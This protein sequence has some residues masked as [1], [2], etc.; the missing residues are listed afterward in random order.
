MLIGDRVLRD[1]AKKLTRSVRDLYE[2]LK[3]VAD[4]MLDDETVVTPNVLI[5]REHNQEIDELLRTFNSVVKTMVLAQNPDDNRS[6]AIL[7][8]S[9]AYYIEQYEDD[10]SHKAICLSNIGILML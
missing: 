10:Y 2:T 8:Y 4:K 6:T 5:F 3:V 7:N 1:R 9:D